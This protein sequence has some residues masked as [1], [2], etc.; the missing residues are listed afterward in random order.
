MNKKTKTRML[1][2][3]AF[4]ITLTTFSQ[5]EAQTYSGRAATAR[6]QVSLVGN[7]GVEVAIAETAALPGTGGTINATSIS[8]SILSGVLS[9]GSSTSSTSGTGGVTTST[10][11]I[12]SLNIGVLSNTVTATVVSSNATASCPM[13]STGGS[14]TITGLQLNGSPV[15]ISGLPNQ[16][17]VVTLVG[18]PVGVLVINEQI[19]T[20][21]SMVVNALRLTVTDPLTLT[22][23]N[24]IV[25][26]SYAAISCAATPPSHLFRGQSYG[27]G[28]RQGSAI[29]PNL[30][31]YAAN[32]GPLPATGGNLSSS[33]ASANILS[34]LVTTGTIDTSTS[35]GAPGGTPNSAQS[36]ATVEDLDI[37]L[38]SGTLTPVSVTADAVHS[39]TLC[40]CGVS[41]PECSSDFDILNINA[42]LLGI[43]TNINLN[44]PTIA[45]SVNVPFVG[46]VD[47]FVKET[48]NEG[49][50]VTANAVRLGV[51][52]LPSLLVNTDV[53]VASSHSG[54]TCGF[55]PTSGDASVSGRVMEHTGRGISGARVTLTSG[56]GEVLTAITNHFGFYTIEGASSGKS[57]IITANHRQHQFSPQ[58]I[59]VDSSISGIDIY[60]ISDPDMTGRKT[61]TKGS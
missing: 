42:V 61:N 50:K 8:T 58:L 25:A 15:S 36:S 23:T 41:G 55:A 54:I 31:T 57:Y 9:A 14:S 20:P 21:G 4:I 18:V 17:I 12:N 56:D 3:T 19:A 5:I 39:E 13:Y 35:A 1:I 59:A 48:V 40:V 53:T 46:G 30:T 38:L 24:V 32:D 26:Q 16:T 27:V 51:A 34:S 2:L 37:S 44:L 52:V 49:N 29:I 11:S 33:I 7:P 28:V 22:Q 47:L 6:A 45:L 60:P 43:P 10:A